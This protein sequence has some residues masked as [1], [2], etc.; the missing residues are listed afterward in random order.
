LCVR[1]ILRDPG[2]VTSRTIP[3]DLELIPGATVT[4]RL[5]TRIGTNADGTRCTGT[6]AAHASAGGLRFYYDAATR[7]SLVSSDSGSTHFHSNGT[8][9]TAD[10]ST[11]V[12]SRT[13]DTNPV[14][15]AARCQD[16]LALTFAGGN[17]WRQIGGNWTLIVP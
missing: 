10:A 11:G 16:S 1:N 6:G 2:R 9:C 13:L 3:L 7:R 4:V 8:A 17:A 12:S 5:L 15:S 14:G